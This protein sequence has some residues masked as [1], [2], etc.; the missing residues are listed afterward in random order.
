VSVGL[1]FEV[2]IALE[3]LS[4]HDVIEFYMFAWP[5]FRTRKK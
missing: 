4:A 5:I 1:T 2:K 3:L